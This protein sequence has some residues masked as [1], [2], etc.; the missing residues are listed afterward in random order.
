MLIIFDIGNSRTKIGL[1][2]KQQLLGVI[3][4]DTNVDSF[5]QSAK[6]AIEWLLDNHQKNENDILGIAIASVVPKRTKQVEAL[7]EKIFNIKPVV[8]STSMK[9]RIILH[10]KNP[11]KLGIDRFCNAVAAYHHYGGTVIIVDWGTATKFDIVDEKGNYLGGAIAPGLESSLKSL[12]ER[13]AQLPRVEL[14]FPPSVIGTGTIECLQSGIMNG[15]VEMS[16]GMIARIK[17]VTG[18]DTV[19]I[20][21]GGYASL[22]KSQVQGVRSIEEYLVLEGARLIFEKNNKNK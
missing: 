11:E 5:R 17:K 10:Y 21:T 16:K 20:A 9:S 22:L 12:S 19:I 18:K 15:I 14:T 3:S 2:S 7:T 4:F 1:F 8:I 13:T 6:Q